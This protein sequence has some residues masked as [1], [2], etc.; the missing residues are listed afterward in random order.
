MTDRTNESFT[1]VRF[2]AVVGVS[3]HPKINCCVY[4]DT[5]QPIGD[6]IRPTNDRKYIIHTI[7]TFLAPRKAPYTTIITNLKYMGIFPDY[8]PKQF[9][10]SKNPDNKYYTNLPYCELDNIIQIIKCSV[11]SLALGENLQSTVEIE[12]RSDQKL[13][14]I[15]NRE[16]P[17]INLNE[18]TI[19]LVDTMSKSPNYKIL[20]VPKCKDN[21]SAFT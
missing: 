2:W 15:R 12:T 9:I 10:V 11:S 1:R 5:Q 21:S 7:I 19:V 20:T 18:S 14:E 16:S 8:N 3:V 4:V 6:V 17:A 13:Q